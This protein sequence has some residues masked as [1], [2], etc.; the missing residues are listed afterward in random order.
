MTTRTV[1]SHSLI[2]VGLLT[3]IEDNDDTGRYC[4]NKGRQGRKSAHPNNRITN[5]E[6]TLRVSR[7]LNVFDDGGKVIHQRRA[8]VHVRRRRRRR[9]R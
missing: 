8:V 1:S 9:Q 6:P 4:E 2:S 5:T 3:V 7:L